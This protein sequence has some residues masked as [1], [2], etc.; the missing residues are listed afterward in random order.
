MD[1]ELTAIT[2]GLTA[3]E[4]A[5]LRALAA[6]LA[7]PSA[8]MSLEAALLRLVQDGLAQRQT[9]AAD[10]ADLA[11]VLG[12]AISSANE[13]AAGTELPASEAF[14]RGRARGLHEAQTLV[15]LVAGITQTDDD[16][17]DDDQGDDH[18]HYR[19]L[20]A[21]WADLVDQRRK[22]ANGNV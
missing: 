14:S 17:A 5:A 4:L 8:P 3:A 9:L 16:Q 10:M 1:T 13:D 20:R 6:D 2:I 22:D 11:G 19:A 15:R 7:L 18:S 12:G 21:N